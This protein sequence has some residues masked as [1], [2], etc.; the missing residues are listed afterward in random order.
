M[1]Q[2][3]ILNAR[4]Y[5]QTRTASPEKRL[6]IAVLWNAILEYQD[7]LCSGRRAD[8]VEAQKLRKWFFEHDEIWPFSFENV[9]AQLDLD[10]NCIRTRLATLRNGTVVGSRQSKR[11]GR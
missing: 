7:F 6:L 3:D 10:P 1:W 11:R 8:N 2:V 4:P 9:C 5:E